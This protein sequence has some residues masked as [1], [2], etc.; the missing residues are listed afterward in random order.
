MSVLRIGNKFK[1]APGR[2]TKSSSQGVAIPCP[3]CQESIRISGALGDEPVRCPR[4]AYPMI[5][6]ADLLLIVSACRNIAGGDQAE[7]AVRILNWLADFHPEAGTAL[8][9]LANRY[10]IPV[11][12]RERWNKMT[13]AYAGGDRGAQ[14]WLMR[15][16]QSNPKTYQADSC[17]NCGAPKYYITGQ[18]QQTRCCYCQSTD[19]G[20]TDNARK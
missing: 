5:R 17:K 1:T 9:D 4:C 16:C 8:G 2:S 20:D 14:E 19:G 11:S 3:K 13:G 10:T 18:R 6:R 12:D 7:S 15:M